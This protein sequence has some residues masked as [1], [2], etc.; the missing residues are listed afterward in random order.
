[1]VFLE[2]CGR[3]TT[4]REGVGERHPASRIILELRG[5]MTSTWEGDGD[6]GGVSVGEKK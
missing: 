4:S 2:L 3:K 1:M 6:V 5:R